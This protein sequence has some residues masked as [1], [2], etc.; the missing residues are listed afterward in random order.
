MAD[1]WNWHDHS[2]DRC[3][4][5]A[6]QSQAP[7]ADRRF[8]RL[9]GLPVSCGILTLSSRGWTTTMSDPLSTYLNDHLA[10]A[11][12]AIELLETLQDGAH[13]QELR[14]FAASVILGNLIGR[15]STTERRPRRRI[16]TS[17]DRVVAR[18]SPHCL[19]IL[20]RRVVRWSNRTSAPE[21]AHI[22]QESIPTNHAILPETD[23]LVQAVRRS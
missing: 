14:A 20:V 16:R 15:V 4:T 12:F 1:L 19:E 3:G 22:D 18:A 11:K 9:F 7:Q 10:G 17:S 5:A 6:G 8:R 23:A 2:I 13:G 21:V